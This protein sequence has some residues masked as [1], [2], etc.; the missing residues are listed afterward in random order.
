MLVVLALS[1]RCESILK[2]LALPDLTIIPLAD[3]ES[4]EPRLLKA[5]KNRRLVEYFFTLTPWIIKFALE[6]FPWSKR[7]T[8]LDSD[9][10]FHNSPSPLWQEINTSPMAFVEHRFSPNYKDRMPLGRFNV[11][12]NSFNRSKDAQH[13]LNWWSEQCLTWCY[14]RAEGE[15]FADQ[16]Y[17]TTIEREFTGVHTL[18]YPGI[19]LAKY[20]LDNYTLSRD[21]EGPKANGLPIIYWH[22][23]ALFEQ[24]DG[25]HKNINARRLY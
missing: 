1:E 9:L 8:Y 23:H 14:D 2:K 11:G 10:Y 24:Q 13:A 5:K 21:Q 16:G 19:N 4:R 3:L 15:K 25:S 17:L 22:M 7:A 6:R 12:W 18:Q 20:N